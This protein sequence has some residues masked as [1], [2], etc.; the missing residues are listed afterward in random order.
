M[1][2]ASEG[3]GDSPPPAGFTKAQTPSPIRPLLAHF[4]PLFPPQPW[5]AVLG[6]EFESPA[7]EAKA[8]A[9]FPGPD[10]VG[11]GAPPRGARRASAR[12]A[13]RSPRATSCGWSAVGSPREV[14]AEPLAR[15]KAAARPPLG[16]GQGAPGQLWAGPSALLSI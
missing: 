8:A 10:P 16:G 15:A 14:P 7:L 3:G 2:K 11:R 9:K 5:W 13:R 4:R 6:L 12:G 1:G